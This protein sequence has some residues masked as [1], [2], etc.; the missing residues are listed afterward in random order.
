ME[1]LMRSESSA[2]R[3]SMRHH[4]QTSA[5]AHRAADFSSPFT[6]GKINLSPAQFTGMYVRNPLRNVYNRFMRAKSPY[7]KPRMH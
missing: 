4:I 7:R 5:G 1:L 6:A 3:Q 2:R